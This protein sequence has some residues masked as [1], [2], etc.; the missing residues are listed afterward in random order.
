MK[1]RCPSIGMMGRNKKCDGFFC[2]FV[3]FLRI[4]HFMQN[5]RRSLNYIFAGLLDSNIK[6]FLFRR[7]ASDG[8]RDIACADCRNAASGNCEEFVGKGSIFFARFRSF[9]YKSQFAGVLFRIASFRA[10]PIRNDLGRKDQ[11]A[12]T[13]V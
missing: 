1:A 3:I 7:F 13:A 2:I 6:R 4:L 10:H 11:H 12:S 5:M 8:M 9:P